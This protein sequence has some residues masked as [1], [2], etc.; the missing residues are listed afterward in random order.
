MRVFLSHSSEDRVFVNR[1]ALDLKARGLDVWYS[2][3]ELGVGDSLASAIQAGIKHASWLIVVL[4]PDSVKSKW[5][6]E[7]LNAGFAKQLAVDRVYILPVLY[8]D[9]E[10][11]VFLRDRIY[12]D[13]RRQYSDG[14]RRLLWTLTFR[15]HP[16]TESQVLGENRLS[17]DKDES[18]LPPLPA[19]AMPG[20]YDLLVRRFLAAKQLDSKVPTMPPNHDLLRQPVWYGNVREIQSLL[21]HP[22]W[23]PSTPAQSREQRESPSL[24]GVWRG[25]TGKL[26]LSVSGDKVKG[27]YDWLG[28][29]YSGALKGVV[30]DVTVLFDWSWDLSGAR[31]S[32][33]FYR[34]TSESLT[35]GWWFRY[36]ELD[37]GA[38]IKANALPPRHWEFLRSPTLLESKRPKQAESLV[39]LDT[40]SQNKRCPCGSGKRYKNC[41]GR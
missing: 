4:S 23:S 2:E 24:A 15:Y 38:L 41:C 22:H 9:C 8:K 32:G 11:P 31:G 40:A 30:K 26:R 16:E 19:P 20:N 1:L 29:E 5:V 34:R 14:L 6:R 37:T 35:G 28:Y 36:E 17:L 27:K 13:F 25:L 39:P 18:N 7:E 12:A 10:I 3:W 21:D 33:V